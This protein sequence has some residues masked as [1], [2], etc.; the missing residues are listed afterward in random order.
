ME[1]VDD[2]EFDQEGEEVEYQHEVEENLSVKLF[3]SVFKLFTNI[4]YKNKMDEFLKIINYVKNVDV[5][6]FCFDPKFYCPNL[7]SCNVEK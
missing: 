7:N 6:M 2:E 5:E 1:V 4:F 3:R